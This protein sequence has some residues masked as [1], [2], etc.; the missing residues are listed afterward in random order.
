VDS[1]LEDIK[2]AVE[3]R[4]ASP[5]PPA[6]RRDRL[7]A[8]LQRAGSGLSHATSDDDKIKDLNRRLDQI[9]QEFEVRVQPVEWFLAFN[10]PCITA[11]ISDSNGALD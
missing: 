7:K 3:Q 11:F 10:N 8:V 1:V 2:V 4:I 6:R 5:P 9:A